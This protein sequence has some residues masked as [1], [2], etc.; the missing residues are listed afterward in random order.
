MS[1]GLCPDTDWDTDILFLQSGYGYSCQAKY[2][3]TEPN[4]LFPFRPETLSLEGKKEIKLYS[5]IK[6][7]FLVAVKESGGKKYDLNN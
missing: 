5:V 4:L 2:D 6:G 1:R 3:G 7:D